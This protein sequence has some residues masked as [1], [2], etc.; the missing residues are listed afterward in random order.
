[1]TT[2]TEIS[3]ET[4]SRAILPL[5]ADEISGLRAVYFFG[6]ASQGRARKNSDVDLAVLAEEAVD[7]GRLFDTAQ[8]CAARLASDVDLVDLRAA[9]LVLQ[10]QIVGHGHR[11]AP[12]GAAQEVDEFENAVLSRYLAFVEER[13]PL[14]AEIV[15]RRAIHAA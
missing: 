11:L 15:R 12:V 1:M 13:R 14:M 6:S 8:V 4:L 5:L 7:A 10:A 9:P 2:V 3:A